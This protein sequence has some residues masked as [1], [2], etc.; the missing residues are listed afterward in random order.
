MVCCQ[1]SSHPHSA[2]TSVIAL[3]PCLSYTWCLGHTYASPSPSLL[4][5]ISPWNT[6]PPQEKQSL[7]TQIWKVDEL[8]A[9]RFSHGDS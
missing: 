2:H 1:P 7:E 8:T 3:L 5:A 6:G 9:F 4:C